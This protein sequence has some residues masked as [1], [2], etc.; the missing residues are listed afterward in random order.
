M[1]RFQF[2]LQ[3]A[4]S[5]HCAAG[6]RGVDTHCLYLRD[7]L[8]CR[9]THVLL[10]AVLRASVYGMH[11]TSCCCS[12]VSLPASLSNQQNAVCKRSPFVTSSM[13]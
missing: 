3:V 4:F 10:T 7:E 9:G 5:L 2:C 1:A 6:Q 13:L 12:D 8:L 11:W